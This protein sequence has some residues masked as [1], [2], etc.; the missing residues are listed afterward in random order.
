M[1]G[2]VNLRVGLFIVGGIGLLFALIWYLGG[3]RTG[4]GTLFESYFSESV[5]GLDVGATVKFR[6]VTIGR[7]AELG[8]V[9]AEYGAGEGIE[10]ARQS[11][12]LVF[13]RYAIDTSKIGPLP[14]TQDAVKLGLRIRIASQ[15]LTG[16]SYLEL[17]FVDPE[18]YPA[19]E[20][21]WKPKGEY[22]P[23]MPSTLTQ[24]QDAAQ[25][26]LAK[27]NRLD[28]DSLSIQITGLI[29]DVRTQLS[30]GDVHDTLAAATTLLRSANDAVQ[31]ADLPGLSADLKR[32]S[33]AIRD[34]VQSEETQKL[35][36]NAALAADRIANV[37]ARL[38]PLIASLQAFSQRAGSGT[39]D[40]E[41][42]LV[43]LLRDTRAV[44]QNLR[45]L[46][47]S[48]RRYPAQI[49]GGPPPHS[50]EQAR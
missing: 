48:L 13:V 14:D 24:V 38:P 22:I 1:I 40:L 26:F 2:G 33:T 23:S 41:Q 49:L 47:D 43:P 36:S 4:R 42:T 31:A 21:P 37:A 44:V 9:N 11:Y 28:I 27:L 16:L 29:G 15:G 17:D 46:T 39:A 25:Q 3:A 19:L 45:E 18:R 10:R 8:L 5:Q 35:L 12:R 30:T 34:T 32:T 7:V 6:G 50:A 20:V